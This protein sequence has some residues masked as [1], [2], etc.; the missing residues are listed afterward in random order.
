MCI[1]I[2]LKGVGQETLVFCHGAS[3]LSLPARCSS[4]EI[5]CGDGSL[6]MCF[7][8]GLGWFALLMDLLCAARDCISGDSNWK[9][10]SDLPKL[11]MSVLEMV[12][13]PLEDPWEELVLF[14]SCLVEPARAWLHHPRLD[15][16]AAEGGALTQRAEIKGRPLSPDMTFLPDLEVNRVFFHS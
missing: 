8:L 3:R 10:M 1:V 15:R 11:E 6:W 14:E 12:K 13:R 4:N 7:W 5:P 16:S 2:P 9:Q